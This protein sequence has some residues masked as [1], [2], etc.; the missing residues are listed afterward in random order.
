MHVYFKKVKLPKKE[1]RC[2]ILSEFGGLV[3]PIEGHRIKGNSVYKKF[4]S[5]EEYLKAY[6]NMIKRDVI[7]NIPLGLSACVYTQ[8]SD[9]EEEANGFITYDREVVKV[10]PSEIKTIN[11]DIK[12]D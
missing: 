10:D 12:L 5:K 2:I 6:K 7:N 8:L 4:A 1:K 9:V 3:L 11:D